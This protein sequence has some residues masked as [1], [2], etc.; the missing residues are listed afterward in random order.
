M[1]YESFTIMDT[2]K[3]QRNVVCMAA[4][5]LLSLAGCAEDSPNSYCD[6]DVSICTYNG[7]ELYRCMNWAGRILGECHYSQ[8]HA[9]LWCQSKG[10]NNATLVNCTTY[11][12]DTGDGTD[13]GDE[14]GYPSWDPGNYV[15][16]SASGSYYV[17]PYLVDIITSDLS[18]LMNDSARLVESGTPD[19][20]MLAMV[21]VNDLAYVL[22][23]ASGDRLISVNNYD[24]GSFGLSDAAWCILRVWI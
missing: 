10:V 15:A 23:L 14:V 19:Y 4:V 3:K 1:C 17:N 13:G 12:G 2:I 11:G 8:L 6:G 22:G 9:N 5:A 21:G 7:A 24:L 18:V 20:W 16:L